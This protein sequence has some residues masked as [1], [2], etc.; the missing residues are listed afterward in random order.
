MCFIPC[1]KNERRKKNGTTNDDLSVKREKM[2]CLWYASFTSALKDVAE[3]RK[4][5]FSV[6]FDRDAQQCVYCWI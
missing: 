2:M 6:V 1:D 3:K 5:K 4:S